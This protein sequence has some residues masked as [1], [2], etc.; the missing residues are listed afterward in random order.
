M[1]SVL[2]AT[3]HAFGNL[4][5]EFPDVVIKN[6]T[7]IAYLMINARVNSVATSLKY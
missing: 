3:T 4:H 5:I 2:I 1:V 6:D 7:K